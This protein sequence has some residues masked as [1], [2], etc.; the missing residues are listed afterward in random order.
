[1]G[2]GSC[3]AASPQKKGQ[4]ATNEPISGISTNRAALP[5]EKK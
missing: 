2:F 3:Q 1:M 4:K 5:I